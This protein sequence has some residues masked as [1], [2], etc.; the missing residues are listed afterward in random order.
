MQEKIRCKI[1]ASHS[2][3]DYIFKKHLCKNTAELLQEENMKKVNVPEAYVGAC[4]LSM[5]DLFATIQFVIFKSLSYC[6][7]EII[8][9]DIKA[10]FASPLSCLIKPDD[11]TK[12]F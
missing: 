11:I 6:F 12:E 5:M 4:Q 3:K 9:F 7:K 8:G 1:K 2:R 10:S